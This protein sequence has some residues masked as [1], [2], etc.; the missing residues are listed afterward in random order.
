MHCPRCAHEKTRVY[1]TDSGL[2]TNRYRKCLGCGYRFMT[3]E[4]LHEDLLSKDY[5][6]YLE[7]I[8]EIDHGVRERAKKSE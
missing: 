2:V 8:G 7:D 4:V 1:G 5:N 6:D 3:T